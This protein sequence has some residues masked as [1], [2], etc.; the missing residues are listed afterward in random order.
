MTGNGDLE[1]LEKRIGYTFSD[2]S[3]LL[4]ALT[5]SSYYNENRNEAGIQDYERL[6]FLGDAVL[7]LVSST[8]LYEKYPD[9]PEGELSRMRAS[10]VCEDALYS[11]A[12]ALFLADH[13]RLGRGERENGGN[14]KKSILSDVVEA[15]TGAVYLDSHMDL[16]VADAFIRRFILND[17]PDS[18]AVKDTKSLLQEYVQHIGSTVHYELLS[19]EGPAHNR[20]YTSAAFI[21]GKMTGKG[22]G[23]SKKHS[24]QEAASEALR[25]LGCI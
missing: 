20:V 15:V 6:E 14:L 1:L 2:K 24:E 16:M 19:E 25:V 21:D 5:H 10:L 9:R 7:E 17:I 22:T 13:V 11:C 4:T 3:L 8:F 12:A 23:S 18:V